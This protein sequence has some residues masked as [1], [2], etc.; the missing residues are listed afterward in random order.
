MDRR[1]GAGRSGRRRG[2]AALLAFVAL[3]AAGAADARTASAHKAAPA[4]SDAAVRVV[5]ADASGYAGQLA[6][7]IGGSKIL[8][9]AY[10]IGRVLLGEPK[11]ADVVPLSDRTLYVMGKA[12][13]TTN[14]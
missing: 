1:A 8:K 13:G 5:S 6:L 2:W 7:P 9:F 11:V 12:A 4:S 10:P 3:S 14:L